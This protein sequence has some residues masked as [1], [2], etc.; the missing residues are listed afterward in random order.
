MC[1]PPPIA[2]IQCLTNSDIVHHDIISHG[3]SRKIRKDKKFL[4]KTAR[5]VKGAA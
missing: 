3:P 2:M 5:R 1:R 4:K